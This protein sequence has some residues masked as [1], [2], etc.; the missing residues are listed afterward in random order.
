MRGAEDLWIENK[1]FEN[2]FVY[3]TIHDWEKEA[4]RSFDF[5]L[6]LRKD[7]TRS[8]NTGLVYSML[9]GDSNTVGLL[10]YAHE[11]ST[12]YTMR[13]ISSQNRWHNNLYS[14]DNDLWQSN[15]NDGNADSI[16]T[17]KEVISGRTTI[18]EGSYF[19]KVIIDKPTYKLGDTM[20]YALLANCLSDSGNLVSL[21]L[22][23]GNGPSK[24]VL[25]EKVL[26][27]E[28]SKF[29]IP[30]IEEGENILEL[31]IRRQMY[32]PSSKWMYRIGRDTVLTKF[33]VE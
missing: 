5:R 9:N 24:P 15:Y 25:I 22:K 10:G 20:E 18:R 13:F 7:S 16:I 26:L 23:T 27:E 28:Y 8:H 11:E 2:G 33:T 12:V 31:V 30:L 19:L 6:Y 1:G 4:L 21:T 17:S 3:Y 14:D 29:K 32:D